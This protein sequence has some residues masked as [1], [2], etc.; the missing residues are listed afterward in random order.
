[1]ASQGG[2]PHFDF[3]FWPSTSSGELNADLGLVKRIL[4]LEKMK[5]A[6][7]GK[8]YGL[9]WEKRDRIKRCFFPR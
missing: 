9:T 1:M 8:G 6:D 2:R 7:N 3:G 5:K 4:D